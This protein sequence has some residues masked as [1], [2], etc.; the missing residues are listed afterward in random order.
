MHALWE[1]RP[2]AILQRTRIHACEIDA[3]LPWL[4]SGTDAPYH[5]RLERTYGDFLNDDTRNALLGGNTRFA[6]IV[7][8]PPYVKVKGRVN[9]YLQF[10]ETCASLLEDGGEMV[11]FVPSD[12]TTLTSGK[13][14]RTLMW[15]EGHLTDLV[16]LNDEHLFEGCAQDVVVL[17]YER[18]E[19]QTTRS[20][21]TTSVNG[22]PT[23]LTFQGG[24][25]A[26]EDPDAASQTRI[27]DIFDIKV[28]MVSGADGVYRHETLGN[29]VF[30][31]RNGA[32]VRYIL[33]RTFPTGLGDA[34]D[35][36]LLAHK[37]ALLARKIRRFA[38][39]N[40]HE[41]GALRNVAWMDAHRGRP[42]IYIDGLTRRPDVGRIGT[43]GYF[44]G[45][46][47]CLM[48]K[49][50]EEPL[51]AWLAWF[52]SDAFQKSHRQSGR[53][54]IGQHVLASTTAPHV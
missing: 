9:L 3:D 12:W 6:S 25:F 7:G 14:L 15:Q 38:E 54:K 43:V 53:F 41:W 5:A 35:A 11:L 37:P 46:V 8:N 42:C 24:V 40:W 22:T 47:L 16:R 19:A 32:H 45:N 13:A 21:R 31:S 18:G 1:R 10:L 28:G 2:E 30:Q 36:H 44:D 20:S 4:E 17:R 50:P 48:P 52:H 39:S 27:G 51:E 34:T 49:N 26:F 33:P 29:A 23:R